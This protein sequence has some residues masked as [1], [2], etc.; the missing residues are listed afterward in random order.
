M[1]SSKTLLAGLALLLFAA[2]A[3]AQMYKWT[4]AKGVVHFSDQPPPDKHAKVEKKSYAGGAREAGLPYALAEAARRH[5]V[6]LYTTADCGPCDQGRALLNQR[7]IPF[8]EKTVSTNEDQQKLKEA[9]GSA[10]LPLLVVGGTRRVGFEATGWN[11]AL[12]SASYP[13]QRRL[14]AN[15]RNPAAVPAAPP[16]PEPEHALARDAAA[17]APAPAPPLKPS[18]APPGFKF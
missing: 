2:S 11:E 9:G 13:Q 5:P 3:S 8:A 10:Q 12:T 14:P 4:D 6:V 16:A 7:G 1:K 18:G 17:D 15:Y